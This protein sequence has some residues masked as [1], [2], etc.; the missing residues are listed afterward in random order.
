MRILH[1]TPWYFPAVRYGGPV[2]SVHGLAKALVARQHEVHVFTTNADGPMDLEIPSGEPVDMDGVTVRYFRRSSGRRLFRSV[3]M[4]RALGEQISCFDVVHTHCAFCW[5]STAAARMARR[6]DVPYVA[7]PRGMLVRDLISRKSGLMKRAWISC[8]ERRNIQSAAAVHVTSELE[9]AELRALGFRHRDIVVVP[10]GVE[11]PEN[12]PELQSTALALTGGR[13][14]LLCLGRINWKKGIDRMI[15]AMPLI[16][17]V[18]LLVVG[19]DEHGYE[20]QLKAI[21]HK[22]G[23]ADRVHFVGP[24]HGIEKWALLRAA[25]AL[26]LPS[27]SENFGNVVLEAMAVGCPVAVTPEVGLAST[28]AEARAGIVVNGD[29]EALAAGLVALLSDAR[30]RSQMG[31]NGRQLAEAKF[32]WRA[33]ASHMEQVYRSIQVRS[34]ASEVLRRSGQAA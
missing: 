32:S 2:Y 7:A 17:D 15:Q 18:H 28:V 27:Y 3:D 9:A 33:V 10:N 22:L 6:Q 8:F 12:M 13:P 30:A 21:T 24:L 19:D 1:V 16:P 34:H 23:L 4:G 31:E 25:R 29:P 20:A 26:V 11:A 5:P 14:F